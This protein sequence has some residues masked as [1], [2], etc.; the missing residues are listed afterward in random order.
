MNNKFS[1]ED[2]EDE[3][4]N[5]NK[6]VKEDKKQEKKSFYNLNKQDS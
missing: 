2:Y 4:I 1:Y 5:D 3:K 6:E